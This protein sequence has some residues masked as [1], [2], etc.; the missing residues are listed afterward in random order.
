VGIVG[1]KPNSSYY[2]YATRENYVYFMNPHTTQPTVGDGGDLK[3]RFSS[4]VCILI[5]EVLLVLLVISPSPP[6]KDV[7]K[8]T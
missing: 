4:L 8:Q 1:G 7:D 5:C 3:K 2:F 6:P